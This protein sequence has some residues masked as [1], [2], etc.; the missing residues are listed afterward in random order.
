LGGPSE[1]V[2]NNPYDT[3]TFANVM[4]NGT[5]TLTD[6]QKANAALNGINLN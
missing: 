1:A 4:S 2:P 3:V 6:E 5:I